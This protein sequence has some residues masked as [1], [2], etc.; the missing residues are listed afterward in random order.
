MSAP[1]PVPAWVPDDLP[2][3]PGV[4]QFEDAH[5]TVLYVGKSVDL[6]RR[7]RGWFYGGGPEDEEKARMLDLARAV[8]CRRTGTDLE[9]RLEE[10]ERIVRGRPKF[11]RA[12]KNRA[13]GWY[14]EMDWSRPYPRL[15]V[16]RSAGKTRARYF[17][18]FRGRRLPEEIADLA[19]KVFCLRTCSGSLDPDPRSSP[20]LQHGV[21]LCTAPCIKNVSLAT[22]RSQ[23]RR[24]ARALDDPDY[25]RRFRERLVRDRER[26]VERL[27][28]EKAADRQ[29]RIEWLDE[30]EAHR[31]A[32]EKPRLDR[33]WLLVLEHHRPGR[34]V[35][36]PVARGRVLERREAAWREPGW[37]EAVGDACY[38]VRVAELQADTVF[39]PEE[40]VTS[41]IVTRW[42]EEEADPAGG[43]EGAR[44]GDG[45]LAL[46]LEAHDAEAAVRRLERAQSS[47][48]SSGSSA[49]TGSA[50]SS[51]SYSPG[52]VSQASHSSA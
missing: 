28:Y 1:S 6:R 2:A 44:A 48:K 12:L 16:T 27:A 47:V 43:D 29:R 52:S 31:H 9:A 46:D 23:A 21:K 5:G 39:P 3:G 19:R 38:A 8:R 24:A 18:P 42:L 22:Y 33:S 10:A 7:V 35:L 25:A 45:G 14:L 26:L 36:V 51:A 41:L 13:R 30:L 49:S 37:R 40:M 32:L 17:G 4:Y 34:R 20:C 11:N 15:R 50:G